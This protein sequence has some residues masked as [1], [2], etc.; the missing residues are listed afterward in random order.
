MFKLLHR[1]RGFIYFNYLFVTACVGSIFLMGPITPLAFFPATVSYHRR[2]VDRIMGLWFLLCTAILELFFNMKFKITGDKFQRGETAIYIMNHRTRLDWMWI[3]PVLYHYG[4]LRKIKI[5]LKSPLKWAPGFGWAM[6]QAGFMFLNRHWDDDKD[7]MAHLVDYYNTLKHPMELLIFPEGTDFCKK[8]VES[9]DRFADRMNKPKYKFVLHPRKTGFQ[10][11]SHKMIQNQQIDYIHD[12][13][14]GYPRNLVADESDLVWSGEF[15]QEVHFHIEKFPITSLPNDL[16]GLGDWVDKRFALKEQR[17][18][19]FY[20]KKQV[21]DRK[22]EEKDHDDC[23]Q[24]R[25]LGMYFALVFW[26][27]ATVAWFWVSYNYVWFFWYE[28]AVAVFYLLQPWW[29]GGIEVLVAV[30]SKLFKKKNMTTAMQNK[31]FQ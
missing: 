26:P 13:T 20:S 25:V 12:I 11:L 9:S 19:K 17:L 21:S 3:W 8:S 7:N 29:F 14:V 16:E 30:V 27:M 1:A 22:F 18:A 23:F 6:Q 2:L 5:V 10:F 24:P 15:P 4:R 28:I 31:K